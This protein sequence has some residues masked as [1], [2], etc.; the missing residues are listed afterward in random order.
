MN[1]EALEIA[2]EISQLI[3]SKKN[4]KIAQ[5]SVVPVGEVLLS[6]KTMVKI[7]FVVYDRDEDVQ[8]R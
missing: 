3:L 7:E 4:C 2:H 6:P 5:M 8:K 1:K